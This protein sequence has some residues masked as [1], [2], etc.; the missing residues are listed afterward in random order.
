MIVCDIVYKPCM[1][2]IKQTFD[3]DNI[4]INLSHESGTHT[5]YKFC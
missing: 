4:M 5:K 2:C 3:N 1:Q